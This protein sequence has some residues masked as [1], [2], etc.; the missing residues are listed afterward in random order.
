MSGASS[1]ASV[2]PTTQNTPV[3]QFSTNVTWETP[4]SVAMINSLAVHL[5]DVS[6][7]G[8]PLSAISSSFGGGGGAGHMSRPN[9][10][11]ANIRAQVVK[12]NDD[13]KPGIAHEFDTPLSTKRSPI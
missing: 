8:F 12:I 1:N 11:V 9:L 3:F 2:R 10:L 7:I 4:L 13:V 5:N 6:C